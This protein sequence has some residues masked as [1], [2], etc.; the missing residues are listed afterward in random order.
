MGSRIGCC[1]RIDGCGKGDPFEREV[2]LAELAAAV[3]LTEMCQS[4]AN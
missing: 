4:S 1:S 3:A 2:T